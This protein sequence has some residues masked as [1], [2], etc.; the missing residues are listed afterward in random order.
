MDAS[1]HALF[2]PVLDPPTEATRCSRRWH[3]RCLALHPLGTSTPVLLR[4][5][6][7][8]FDGAYR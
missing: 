7:T 4:P 1:S 5:F 3:H 8:R 6:L 2:T